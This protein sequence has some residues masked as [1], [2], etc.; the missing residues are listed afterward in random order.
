MS[1]RILTLSAA[2][3]AGGGCVSYSYH[4]GDGGDYYSGAASVQYRYITPGGIYYS[5]SPWYG[6]GYGYY[7]YPGYYGY[8]GNPYY[9]GHRR[10]GYYGY[11]YWGNPYYYG[12]AAWGYR[13]GPYKPRIEP[14]PGGGTPPPANPPPRNQYGFDPRD[15]EPGSGIDRPGRRYGNPPRMP[16]TGGNAR[17]TT[18]VVAPPP[19]APR[20]IPARPLPPTP[21]PTVIPTRPVGTAGVPLPARP[22]RAPS[23]SADPNDP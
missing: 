18:Q 9:Y 11:P 7:D 12:G 23:R 22:A 17:P 14:P 10:H 8:Y 5:H 16:I 20:V 1:I 3:L 19:S 2:L 21:A 13:H 15:F 6:Y 4:T